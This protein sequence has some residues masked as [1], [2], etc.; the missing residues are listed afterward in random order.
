MKQIKTNSKY[1]FS[2]YFLR[3]FDLISNFGVILFLEL[4]YFLKKHILKNLPNV[5]F[6][7]VFDITANVKAFK[8]FLAAF[9]KSDGF[10]KVFVIARTVPP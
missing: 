9:L 8:K 1:F 7:S 5:P 3:S 10:L 2:S 4:S 6:K